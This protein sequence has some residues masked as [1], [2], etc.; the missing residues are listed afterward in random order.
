MRTSATKQEEHCITHGLTL[1]RAVPNA[2][3]GTRCPQSKVLGPRR[4]HEVTRP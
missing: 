3:S 4:N 2:Q 1:S